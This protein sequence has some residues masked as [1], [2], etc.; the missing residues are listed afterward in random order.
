M[1]YIGHKSTLLL[2]RNVG[3]MR[4]SLFQLV[5][6]RPFLVILAFLTFA[7]LA[8]SG[9]Q[10]LVFKSDYR[11]FFDDENPEL[12]A[13]ESMQ[14]IYSKSDNVSFIVVPPKDPAEGQTVFTAS[15]LA[16]L[17]NLTELS[18]QIPYS[19]RVDSLTNFQY[20]FAEDD[21][22]VEDLSSFEIK[23][24]SYNYLGE[25]TLTVKFLSKQ[26]V[27]L[28]TYKVEQVPTDKAS[29][30]S[31]RI[32]WID[33]EEYRIVKVE[34][35]DRKKSLLKTLSYQDF[36]LYLGKY[37]RANTS[38]MVNHQ[39]GKETELQWHNYNFQT[40][41]AESDFSKSALKRGR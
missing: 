36:K 10:K 1:R 16:A 9:A 20:T 11:I 14:K 29:G 41:L 32:V 3:L 19:T 33:K 27:E 25:E 18:W 31:K 7:F 35:Y 6:K 34:F 17:K 40:G 4:D 8:A 24:Y 28:E 2:K 22:I 5:A 12:V 39:T 13:Y 38:K 26:E 37:W 21:M 23:K 15:H 30:Y